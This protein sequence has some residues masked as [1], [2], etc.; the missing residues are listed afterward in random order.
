ML[1]EH[2]DGPE[3]EQLS[4]ETLF[5][6]LWENYIRAPANKSFIQPSTIFA[7]EGRV[8]G[9][10]PSLPLRRRVVDLGTSVLGSSDV[11]VQG[12]HL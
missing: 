9:M 7:H 11:P 5:P 4:K 10:N 3:Y 1:C 12:E 2:N 8:S 6:G